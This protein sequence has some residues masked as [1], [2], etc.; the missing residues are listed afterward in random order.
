MKKTLSILFVT[1]FT[2][3]V[4]SL[5]VMSVMQYRQKKVRHVK[6]HLYFL[7]GQKFM[8]IDEVKKIIHNHDSIIG[9]PVKDVSVSFIEKQID[10]NPYVK[11]VD[12]YFNI[13]GNL[14]VNV[15]EKEALMRIYNQSGQSCYVDKSGD[16]FPLS[17]NFSARVIPV[18][19]YLNIPLQM[20]KNVSDSLYVHSLLPGLYRLARQIDE[21]PFL[22]AAI[23]QIYV[24]S[25]RKVDLIPEIGR[26]LIRFGNLN[27]INI[28]LENLEAF[29]KQALVKEGWNKYK[30]IN[31]AYTN[32]VVCTKN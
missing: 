30:S 21:D 32:Q 11:S 4:F 29:Y 25:R 19:G 31:L 16:L 2:L 14:M 17:R 26:H 5:A 24:N 6:V 28:K 20:G 18:N 27:E 3:A 15:N 22:K 13:L 7:D 23:S 10:K 12:A 8:T 9:K 1:L